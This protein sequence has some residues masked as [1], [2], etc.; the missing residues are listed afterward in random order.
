[1]IKDVVLSLL[2]GAAF[3]LATSDARA[4]DECAASFRTL[5][6]VQTGLKFGASQTIP[7]LNASQAIL[8][9]GNSIKSDGDKI[10]DTQQSGSQ[11]TMTVGPV[12]SNGETPKYMSRVVADESNSLVSILTVLKPGMNTD[13]GYIEKKLC[14]T[15][16]SA[17]S[18]THGDRRAAAQIDTAAADSSLSR[19]APTGTPNRTAPPQDANIL[20][21][22]GSF[23]EA[24]AK[25]ALQ[26]G[27]ATI[28]GQACV[29]RIVENGGGIYLAANQK[30]FLFPDSPYLDEFVKLLHSAK[31]GRDTVSGDP[32]FLATRMEAMTNS[33][34]QFQFSQMK[35]GKYYLLTEMRTAVSGSRTDEGLD[36]SGP[37]LVQ[38][39]STEYF[40][41]HYDDI[42]DKFV[43]VSDGQTLN[44]VLTGHPSLKTLFLPNDNNGWVGIVGCKGLFDR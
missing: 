39:F 17:E 30:V 18:A 25:A 3:F 16:A 8:Q 2:W 27:D 43:T 23:D 24:V 14:S 1:M 38:T 4:T 36:G 42:L 15:L 12:T 41:N 10:Y 22:S 20:K 32:Q 29:K 34:G 31:R 21:P 26:P 9:I 28:S 37:Q 6:S 19:T 33:K 40:T 44:I 35:P 5:G 13:I 11:M 7:G